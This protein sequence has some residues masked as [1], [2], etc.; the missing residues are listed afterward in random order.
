VNAAVLRVRGRTEPGRPVPAHG[1]DSDD[2]PGRFA[3]RVRRRRGPSRL[4]G[5]GHSSTP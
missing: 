5:V 4:A 2:T 1:V 3:R